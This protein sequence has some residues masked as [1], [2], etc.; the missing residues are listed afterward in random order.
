MADDGH[1]RAPHWNSLSVLLD[2]D[3]IAAEEPTVPKASATGKHLDHISKCATEPRLTVP[4]TATVGF[5]NPYTS[6][7]L[8]VLGDHESQAESG[9]TKKALREVAAQH[10]HSSSALQDSHLLTIE[11]QANSFKP[12]PERAQNV[13]ATSPFDAVLLQSYSDASTNAVAPGLRNDPFAGFM[14]GEG[15]ANSSVFNDVISTGSNETNTTSSSR[16]SFDHDLLDTA[17]SSMG[18]APLKQIPSDS[19]TTVPP[20]ALNNELSPQQTPYASPVTSI[21]TPPSTSSFSVLNTPLYS[22]APTPY[23]AFEND[24]PNADDGSDFDDSAPATINR[25]PRKIPASKR[26]I[27]RSSNEQECRCITCDTWLATLFLYGASAALE[28]PHVIEVR[29]GRRMR[30]GFQG[31]IEMTCQICSNLKGFGVVRVDEEGECAAEERSKA[32]PDFGIEVICDKC[33]TDFS[34][35]RSGRW[36][37]KELFLQG[38]KTCRLP[39][40]RPGNPTQFRYVTYRIPILGA[41][42]SDRYGG[43]IPK[44]EPG[45]LEAVTT[46][47]ME[48]IPYTDL[49]ISEALDRIASDVSLFWSAASL[50]A[51]ADALTMQKASFAETWPMVVATEQ[52]FMRQLQFFVKGQFNP[53][54]NLEELRGKRVRRLLCLGFF[55]NPKAKKKKSKTGDMAEV[56]L[57]FPSRHGGV[58][59]SAHVTAEEP[60]YLIGGV[61]IETCIIATSGLDVPLHIWGFAVWGRGRD[62]TRK[63]LLADALR[64]GSKDIETYAELDLKD[65]LIPMEMLNDR[66]IFMNGGTR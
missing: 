44:C 13:S 43:Y 27:S 56:L 18:L 23:H 54:F 8:P 39:H 9:S 20:Q 6:S 40:V 31:T 25:K 10:D 12:G 32:K 41:P 66:D 3:G 30:G 17:F 51:V 60:E 34:V 15:S 48:N 59:H 33:F 62:R 24:D 57:L 55:P 7:L 16:V 42:V 53:D 2:D 29:K 5:N 21:A 47:P 19:Y 4:T 36:R 1:R 52:E 35:W 38:R 28:M 22:E 63:S 64:S 45:F 14:G 58:D 11:T 26:P 49:P 37:P 46:T 65:Y 61:I 50:N